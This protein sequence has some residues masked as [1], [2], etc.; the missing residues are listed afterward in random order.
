MEPGSVIFTQGFSLQD[1]MSVLEVREIVLAS[2]LHIH[3][4]CATRFFRSENQGLIAVS[5][6]KKSVDPL[7]TVYSKCCL[8]KFVGYWIDHSHAR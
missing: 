4:F 8:K 1:A 3:L 6:Y 2:E 7:S 5:L